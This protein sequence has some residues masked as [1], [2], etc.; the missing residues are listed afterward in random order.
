[1]G[2]SVRDILPG[3]FA[4]QYL[5]FNLRELSLARLIGD[6]GWLMGLLWLASGH[7]QTAN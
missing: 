6:L 4:W 2:D 7:P 3:V 5:C 1:M